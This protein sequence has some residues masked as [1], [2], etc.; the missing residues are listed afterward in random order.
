FIQAQVA[1]KLFVISNARI[2]QVSCF[3]IHQ[4]SKWLFFMFFCILI[5]VGYCQYHFS[6]VVIIVRY[7]QSFSCG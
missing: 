7:L 3:V 4:F 6:S 1:S 2:P 5:I